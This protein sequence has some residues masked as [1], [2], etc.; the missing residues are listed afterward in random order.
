VESWDSPER[1]SFPAEFSILRAEVTFHRIG[2]MPTAADNRIQWGIIGTGGI[3]EKMVEGLSMLPD[4]KIVAIASRKIE[5]AQAF[6]LKH[7]IETAYGRYEELARDPGV[8]VVYVATP[9][10][11]HCENT[12]MCLEGG[13][14]VLCEKPL[15]MN[16]KELLRM[17][18]KAREKGLFLMEALWTRFLPSIVR[19]L[20]LIGSG[21]LGDVRHI[22]SDFGV[23]RD[24]DPLHRAFNKELGGGS[25]L[26]LGIYPLFLTL[27]LW[28]E[29]DLISAVPDIGPT[30]VDESL[31]LTLKYNDGRIA[32]LFSS[33]T[34]NSTVETHVCGTRGRLKLNRWW[35]SPVKLELARGEGDTRTIDPH[36][37]G[38]G[39]N[40]EAEEV[41][42]CM[43][44]GKKESILL[45]LAFSLQ[46]IRLMDKIRKEIGLR[47]A[48][49]SK[50]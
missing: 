23:K 47:Y 3:A 20:E 13:K 8:D 44:T 2:I 33:F 19:T 43:R 32:S 31:A 10:P 36:A 15:A 17:I 30:G 28:G 22:K 16:E 5:R 35:F 6:A 12:L 21:E 49:D 50:E 42:S 4:A 38:N 26:D 11:F 46:L 40:Y 41:M 1:Y 27:L 25:L 45:P 18:S 9:H 39:Y 29:P 34:V 24:F 14:A 7:R 48:A 37:V